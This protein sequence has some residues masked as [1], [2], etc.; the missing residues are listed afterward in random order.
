MPSISTFYGSASP[1]ALRN[2]QR[3][4]SPG[5]FAFAQPKNVREFAIELEL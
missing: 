2:A 5:S 4:S 3:L 1:Q